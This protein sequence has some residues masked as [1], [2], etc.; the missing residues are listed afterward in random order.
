MGKYLIQA[1][2]PMREPESYMVE[3]LPKT[4]IAK[5]SPMAR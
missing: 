3:V 4:K 1:K 2:W 5:F